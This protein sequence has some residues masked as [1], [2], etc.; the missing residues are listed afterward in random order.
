MTKRDEILDRPVIICSVI[1]S[2]KYS[3]SG[4]PLRL[5]NGSTAMEGLSGRGN[6][7]FST[8]ATSVGAGEGRKDFQIATPPATT[9]SAITTARAALCHTG[10]GPFSSVTFWSVSGPVGTLYTRMGLTM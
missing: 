10:A 6:A 1:P 8:E 5:L 7:I 4:S 2:L 9:T 3:C